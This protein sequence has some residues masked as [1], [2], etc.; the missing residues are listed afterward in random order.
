MNTFLIF[1]AIALH[2]ALGT[3]VAWPQWQTFQ[4]LD[5]ARQRTEREAE[6]MEGRIKEL[7]PLEAKSGSAFD[8]F[9]AAQNLDPAGRLQRLAAALTE[10][11]DLAEMD[12]TALRALDNTERRL[13]VSIEAKGSAASIL[14]WTTLLNRATPPIRVSRL[15]LRRVAGT[16]EASV[17]AEALPAL[18]YRPPPTVPS[19]TWK[20]DP[21]RKDP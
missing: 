20:K 15:T 10:W 6:Q 18:Q 13:A 14:K 2:A 21:F 7:A 8:A 17:E 19:V 16:V 12:V 5:R 11:S 1:L 3:F 4:R 9:Q